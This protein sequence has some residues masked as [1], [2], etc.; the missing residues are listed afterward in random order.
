[1]MKP[2]PTTNLMKTAKTILPLLFIY[3]LAAAAAPGAETNAPAGDAGSAKRS[4]AALIC[5]PPAGKA[6]FGVD[7][8]AISQRATTLSGNGLSQKV[9]FDTGFRLDAQAGYQ[10]NPHWAAE[11]EF[12]LIANHAKSTP[13]LE[14]VLGDV[15]LV[16]MPILANVIYTQPLGH[17]WSASLGGGL[18]MVVSQYQSPYLYATSSKA[19]FAW[20]GMAGIRYAISSHCDLGVAYKILGTSGYDIGDVDYYYFG[21]SYQSGLHSDGNLSQSLLLSFVWRF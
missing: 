1:M 3:T 9:S 10:F 6:Y 16:Q 13:A 20:Q 17:G 7:A 19:A 4:G 18:G 21:Y 12:G 8:G 11:I 2:Q 14:T 15:D 5:P